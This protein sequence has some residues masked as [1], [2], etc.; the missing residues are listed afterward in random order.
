MSETGDGGV[1]QGQAATT[2]LN[3]ANEITVALFLRNK[4]ALRI[5]L[6]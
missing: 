3:A 6:R 4:S 5:S 2:A 1:E